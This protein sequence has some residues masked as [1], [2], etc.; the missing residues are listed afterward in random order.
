MVGSGIIVRK[1]D[2]E[3]NYHPIHESCA[4]VVSQDF[5]WVTVGS[6][7]ESYVVGFSILVIVWCG[8]GR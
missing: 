1:L 6:I 8:V 2:L 7:C 5:S 3:F 4:T